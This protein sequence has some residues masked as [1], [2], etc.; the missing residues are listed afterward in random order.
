MIKGQNSALPDRRRRKPRE[1][2][3]PGRDGPVPRALKRAWQQLPRLKFDTWSLGVSSAREGS[4]FGI[5]TRMFGK[6][7]GVALT[8]FFLTEHSVAMDAYGPLR[9][10]GLTLIRVHAK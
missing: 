8:A 1:S 4:P 5:R 9:Q 10:R 2:T 6:G 3:A 7:T